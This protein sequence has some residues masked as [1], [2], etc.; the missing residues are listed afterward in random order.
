MTKQPGPQRSSGSLGEPISAA[1]AEILAALPPKPERRGSRWLLGVI[2]AAIGIALVYSVVG[3]KNIGWGNVAHFQFSAVILSGVEVTLLLTVV[4]QAVGI[5]IGL[6]LAA[7]RLSGNV[8]LRWVT[9]AY[10]WFFRGTP[11]LVQ[12]IFWFNL[13]AL[14]PKLGFSGI[15]INT[16]AIITGFTAAV[17]G[18]GLHEG[19]LMSEIIRAGVEGIDPGQTEAGLSIGMTRGAILRQI[20]FP[21]AVRIIIPPTGNDVIMMLKNTALVAFIAGGDLLTQASLI[22]SRNFEVISLLVVASLWY[23]FFVT[24]SSVGQ[25]YLERYMAK[26]GKV[27]AR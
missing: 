8:V 3:N 6:V 24:I 5:V 9:V 21:Q 15:G 10:L 25:Y 26:S 11:I 17:L 19:A 16:N 7:M 4:C 23:L 1:R 12:L 14:F 2:V 22:Y 27:A 13:A 20:V 18:L